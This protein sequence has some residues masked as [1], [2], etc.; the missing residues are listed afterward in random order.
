MVFDGVRRDVSGGMRGGSFWREA[1]L[2]AGG[3]GADAPVKPTSEG[4]PAGADETVDFEAWQAEWSDG[5]KTAFAAYENGLKSAL[6]KERDAKSEMEK[7]LRTLLKKTDGN[8]DLQKQL[9]TMADAL[10]AATE[11]T[12]FMTEAIGS[13]VRC[14]QPKLAWLAA[15]AD[16]LIDADGKTDWES[17]KKTYPQLFRDGGT[18]P[19]A[20]AGDGAGGGNPVSMSMD[21]LLRKR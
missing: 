1:D 21:E 14:A 5:Q 16:G 15:K 12:K 3:S 11:E 17:L 9:Q 18:F 19:T 6:K 13:E 4:D 7:Q 20:N 8:E 10:K 2:G